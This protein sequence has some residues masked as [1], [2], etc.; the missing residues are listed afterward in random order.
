[1]K[2]FLTNHNFIRNI[3]VL[4]IAALF[5]GQP[6]VKVCV[7]MEY[8]VFILDT[9]I[10]ASSDL[11]EYT[12]TELENEKTIT[13]FYFFESK[14]GAFVPV[15]LAHFTPHLWSDCSQE[16]LIPPPEFVS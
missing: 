8:D 2:I 7:I 6:V 12:D 10:D 5:L 11:E 16:I 13:E 9:D 14:N 3:I 4:L 1:L 15:H